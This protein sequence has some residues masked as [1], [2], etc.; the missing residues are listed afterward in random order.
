M[1]TPHHKAK[2]TETE[3]PE[4]NVVAVDDDDGD[5]GGG[6]DDDKVEDEKHKQRIIVERFLSRQRENRQFQ[7]H[8]LQSA[9]RTT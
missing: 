7:T 6:G 3:T 2:L 9:I 4:T 8:T 5:V 1:H